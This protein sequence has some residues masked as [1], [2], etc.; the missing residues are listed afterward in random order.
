M[1]ERHLLK[2]FIDRFKPVLLLFIFCIFQYSCNSNSYFKGQVLDS[3]N[4][5]IQDVEIKFV[6]YKETQTDIS[7]GLVNIIKA[8][9]DGRFEF[10]VK[11]FD[12]KMK[13]GIVPVKEGYQTKPISFTPN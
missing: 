1:I 11:Q 13:L 6:A 10:F 5:P 12:K 9:K 2:R 7:G 3:Q 4:K 8:N